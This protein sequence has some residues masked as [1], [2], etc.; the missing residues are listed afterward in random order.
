MWEREWMK[1]LRYV[2]IY[3]LIIQFALGTFLPLDL[4]YGYRF[5]YSLVKDNLS[6]IDTILE[7]IK[8]EIDKENLEDYIIILGDSVAF[9]GPGDSEHSL[10]FYMEQ[11]LVE[12]DVRV[13]NLSMP[14]MQLGDVY[15]MLLKL[16]KY[17]ISTDN[18]IFNL[19]Y[20][21]FVER[22]PDPPAVFWLK[23]DLKKLDKGSYEVVAENLA[24]NDYSQNQK[25][26]WLTGLQNFIEEEVYPRIALFKYKDFLR[27]GV[28]EKVKGPASDALGDDRPWY[29]KEGL[30]SLLE[31]PEYQKGF[32]PQP[33]DMSRANP[34]IFFCEK[35]LEHQQGKN[36]LAFLAGT[37]EELMQVEVEKEGYQ[38]NLH[39]IDQYFATKDIKYLNLQGQIPQELFSDHVHLTGEG[40]AQL[41]RIIVE[42]FKD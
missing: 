12:R 26:S 2:I 4:V 3:L 17:G 24:L 14:A 11:M 28:A 40:Y 41:A 30:R 42:N 19:T 20:A 22:N 23:D 27:K 5:D 10:G 34:Q 31:T 16:D 33:F 37:N 38:A 7:K 39:L 21:G 6:L 32:L 25:K 9:S 18:L 36:N 15:T 29:E 8:Q 13:F 1:G 35:I